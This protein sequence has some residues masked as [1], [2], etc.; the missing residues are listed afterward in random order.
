MYGKVKIIRNWADGCLI[1]PMPKSDSNVAKRERL[2]DSFVVLYSGN[3][4]LFHEL[5]TLVL[6]AKELENER[7]IFY[8]LGEAASGNPWESWLPP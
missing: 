1:R 2:V 4:G 5:G 6:A 7:V 8:L 3:M